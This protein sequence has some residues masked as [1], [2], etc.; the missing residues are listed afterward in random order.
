M[1][2]DRW[3]WDSAET[4]RPVTLRLLLPVATFSLGLSTNLFFCCCLASLPGIGRLILPKKS[5]VFNVDCFELDELKG[6]SLCRSHQLPGIRLGVALTQS[7]VSFGIRSIVGKQTK[8][9][10]KF[11]MKRRRD[12]SWYVLFPHGVTSSWVS[13]R[14]S[15]F[16]GGRDSGK[17]LIIIIHY[18]SSHYYYYSL[19]SSG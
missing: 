17:V 9:E 8:Q 19:E 4:L 13:C 15:Y 10:T 11:K 5:P 2:V 1:R 18:F 7:R 3:G 14:Q 12:I 16:S 6:H